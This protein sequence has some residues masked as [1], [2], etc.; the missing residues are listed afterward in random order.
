[1]EKYQILNNPDPQKNSN[2]IKKKFRKK[3]QILIKIKD[4]ESRL[5]KIP[6][7]M[8]TQKFGKIAKPRIRII[9]LMNNTI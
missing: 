3:S 9:L 6:N 7:S 8:K 5:G 1:M 4:P 2:S